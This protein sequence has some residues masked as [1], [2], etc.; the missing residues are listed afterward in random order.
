MKRSIVFLLI[1]LSTQVVSAQIPTYQLEAILDANSCTSVD[2][3]PD[4]SKICARAWFVAGVGVNGG[5]YRIF[6]ANTYLPIRDYNVYGAPWT[7]LFSSDSAYIWTTTYYG[8]YLDK[9]DVNSC[10]LANRLDL[11]NWT[12]GLAFDSQRRY[13][14]VGENNP[15]GYAIGTLQK[16]DTDSCSVDWSVTLNGEPGRCIAVGPDDQFVYQV[17]HN[18]GTEMLYKIR[19]GDGIVDGNLPLPGVFSPGISVSPD[20]KNVYVPYADANLVYVIDTITCTISD[21]WAIETPHGFFASPSGTHALVTGKADPNIRV[22]DL[23]SAAVVQT[24]DVGDVGAYWACSKTP[25]WDT[26]RGKV[27]LN[28]STPSGGVAVLVPEVI[29]V[30]IDIKSLS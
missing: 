11:G 22:F 28:L 10:G 24:I 2:M 23:S 27:Y 29:L 14:Y 21:T 26:N 25:Y 9:I 7:G 4:G 13:L 16:F 6:D 17:T 19:T 15:G 18:S 5:G 8:G 3:S 12:E 30:D 1:L 20:G